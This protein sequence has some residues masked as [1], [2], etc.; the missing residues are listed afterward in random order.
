M[1]DSLLSIEGLTAGYDRAAVIR[2]VDLTVGRARW[3][4]C[5]V[6][7]EPARRRRSE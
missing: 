2:D 3:S 6:R 5:S 4:R 1:T 7:T